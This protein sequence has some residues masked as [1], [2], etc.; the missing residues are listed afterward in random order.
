MKKTTNT[1]N[2]KGSKAETSY[3][4]ITAKDPRTRHSLADLEQASVED[5]AGNL[6]GFG[7]RTSDFSKPENKFTLVRHSAGGFSATYFPSY[8]AALAHD[9]AAAA[10]A[11]AQGLS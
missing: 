1:A 3:W 2:K 8:E 4:T 11:L 5:L 9:E 10:K 7:W 6:M